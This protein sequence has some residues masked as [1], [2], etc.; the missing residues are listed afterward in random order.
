MI[1]SIL[2][3]TFL[4]S[5]AFLSMMMIYSSMLKLVG[6]QGME[7]SF[8]HWGYSKSF[9]I[10]IGVYEILMGT[11]VFWNKTRIYGLI[12]ISILM[13]GA[14]YT[15]ISNGEYDQLTTAGFVFVVATSAIIIRYMLIKSKKIIG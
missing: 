10:V 9:M 5:C 8:M 13:L 12:G 7:E 3:Y 6:Y 14:L 11:I 1:N 2:K 4:I 15:H